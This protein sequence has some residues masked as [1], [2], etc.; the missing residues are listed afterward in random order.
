[1]CIR[2][3]RSTQRSTSGAS[4]ERNRLETGATP[5]Q[6]WWHADGRRSLTRAVSQLWGSDPLF[7]PRNERLHSSVTS[8]SSKWYSVVIPD[9]R[10]AS[11][12]AKN[13]RTFSL[14]SSRRP[15]RVI[16]TSSGVGGQLILDAAAIHSSPV[17]T[18]FISPTSSAYDSLVYP[19]G[20][21]HA[22]ETRS[23]ERTPNP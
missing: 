18:R 23:G 6:S 20:V 17:R 22:C 21:P 7:S 11:I 5:R 9:D 10:S 13:S 4:S 12:S 19:H 2:D 8:E 16:E 14:E 1:M 3:R 15:S